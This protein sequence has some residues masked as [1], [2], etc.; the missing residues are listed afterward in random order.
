ME[1]DGE[2]KVEDE[3]F[4]REVHHFVS[5]LRDFNKIMRLCISYVLFSN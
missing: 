5:A 2:D 4:G 1:D 3:Q